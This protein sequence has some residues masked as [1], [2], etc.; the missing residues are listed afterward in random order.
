MK[1]DWDKLLT[2]PGHQF[3]K[4]LYFEDSTASRFRYG[5]DEQLQFCL[6]FRFPLAQRS[7][8]VEPVAMANITLAEQTIEGKPALVLTLINEGSKNLFGDL[9][10]S[11]VSQTADI[12]DQFIKDKFIQLCNEWFGLFD[13]LTGRLHKTDLQAIFAELYFLEYLL[14]SSQFT[15]NEVLN[16]WKGPFGKSHDFVLGENLFEIKSIVESISLV[17]ISSEYQLDYLNGENLFLLVYAFVSVPVDGMII[18]E[19]VD[20]VAVLLRSYTGVNMNLFWT[21][22]GKAGLTS[23]NLADYDDFKFR[24]KNLKIY[25]CISEDF[26]SLKRSLLPD[27]VRNVKYELALSSIKRFEIDDISAYI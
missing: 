26:P 5:I 21:A 9:I 10:L 24:I 4:T 8:L 14:A 11:L 25:N 7:R 20:K 16:S 13:P 6:F 19:L 3:P 27:A 1:L 18:R 12:E 23:N 17:H 22:L 15:V 2:D